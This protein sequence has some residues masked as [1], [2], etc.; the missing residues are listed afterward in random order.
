MRLAA[1]GVGIVLLASVAAA[2]SDYEVD[3]ILDTPETLSGQRIVLPSGEDLSIEGHIVEIPPRSEVG[4]HQHP[5]PVFMYVLEGTL[6]VET[7]EGD[8]FTYEAGDALVEDAEV[9]INNSNPG[10][11]PVKFLAV[12][13]S[14]EGE[15]GIVFPD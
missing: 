8:Q 1:L 14:Q 6:V 9:W 4:R 13:F 2:Q 15:P 11:Q 7:D 10:D 12:L 5:A 3:V